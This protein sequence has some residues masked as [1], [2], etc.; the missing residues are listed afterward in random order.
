LGAW[1]FQSDSC[2]KGYCVT[3][4]WATATIRARPCPTFQTQAINSL[5][6]LVSWPLAMWPGRQAYGLPR[7]H[8][9]HHKTRC[10]NQTFSAPQ[11]KTRFIPIK[12]RIRGINEL[13]ISKMCN[14]LNLQEVVSGDGRLP[15]KATW[16][17]AK[18]KCLPRHT[19]ALETVLPPQ[20][21][22]IAA[23]SPQHVTRR[24]LV[25]D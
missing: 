14:S 25:L 18:I 9:F 21:A 20:L 15:K 4:L 6:K 17:S 11:C 24:P 22:R 19:T 12:L 3:L 23:S 1:V 10:I 8:D 13:R 16:P 5:G 2:T 7:S